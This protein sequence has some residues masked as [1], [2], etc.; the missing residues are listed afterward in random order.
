MIQITA[1]PD[2]ALLQVYAKR[3]ECYTD[4][5]SAHLPNSVSL[6]EF[7][8]AF[9]S[10]KLFGLERLILKWTVKRPSTAADILA[11]SQGTTD[12]FAAWSVEA[13]QT[14]QL[15]LCDMQNRTRSWLM[16]RSEA[17]GTRVF[18]GSAVTPPHGE[19]DLGLIFKSLLGFHKIYSR[20][21]LSSA[22]KAL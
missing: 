22:I 6:S 5:F 7:I 8:T 14:D 16:A 13:R 1:L 19:T 10:T 11:L 17:D 2:D 21:L 12:N 18:F 9:Y 15:L 20:A 4:C 3:P